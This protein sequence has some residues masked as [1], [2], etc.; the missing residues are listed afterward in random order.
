MDAAAVRESQR[1]E[2][3]TQKAEQAYLD[4]LAENAK[5]AK[6]IMAETAEKLGSMKAELEEYRSKTQAFIDAEKR[7]EEL[8][9]NQDKYKVL[10]SEMD[11]KEIASLSSII[12]LLRNARPI[13]KI[14][15]ES[16]YRDKTNEMINRVLGNKKICGIYKIT[17][18][19]NNKTYIGQSVDVAERW[20]QHLK[21]GCGIDAPS[22]QLYTA[23]YQDRPEN[24]TFE[25]LEECLRENLNERETYWIDFYDCKNWGFNETKG[26]SKK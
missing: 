24:F 3:E 18:I 25:L 20:K 10:I 1:Y 12:P 23:M 8:E 19:K 14:I 11:I 6:E 7:K 5:N 4:F 15:W 16:Y 13:Y 26:G 9:L 2:I 21:C 17:E 22:N